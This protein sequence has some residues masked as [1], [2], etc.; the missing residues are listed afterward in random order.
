MATCIVCNRNIAD[1]EYDMSCKY[2]RTKH[3]KKEVKMKNENDFSKAAI[4]QKLYHLSL[5]NV[6]VL[7]FID[8]N[9]I[10]VANRVDCLCDGH[11]IDINGTNGA[12][13]K[14]L[15]WRKPEIEFIPDPKKMVKKEF[16][17][18]LNI[19]IDIDTMKVRMA[20]YSMKEKAINYARKDRTGDKY[21]KVAHKITIPYEVEE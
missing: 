7:C 13:E 19:Y 12:G 1:S 17:K 20:T 11:S 16:V 10:E 4:G 5:G 9:R 8:N 3:E 21:L 18:Y 2:C 14:V 15:Y 6:Y